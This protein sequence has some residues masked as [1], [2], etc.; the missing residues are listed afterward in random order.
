M[1]PRRLLRIV[2]SVL[3]IAVVWIRTL[4]EWH[5]RPAGWLLAS[6]VISVILLLVILMEITAAKRG[7]RSQRDEVPKHPLGL[8]S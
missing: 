7:R 4:R 8:D 2:L 3:I 6:L 5:E 1:S